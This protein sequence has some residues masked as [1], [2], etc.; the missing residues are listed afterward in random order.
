MGK[1]HRLLVGVDGS[2]ASFHA[3][4]ESCKLTG[5]WVTVVAVAPFYEGDLRS[6]WVSNPRALLTEAC[7]QALKEAQELADE[8][9]TVINTV[10]AVGAPHE[11]IVELAARGS[12]DLIVMG[13]KGQSLV[14]RALLGS[15]SRRVIGYSPVDVLVVPFKAQVGWSKILLATD[16]S[17]PSQKATARALELAQ[18]YG[19]ELTVLTVRESLGW[20][21]EEANLAAVARQDPLQDHVA[22][23]ALEAKSR[24]LSAKGLVL[25]GTPYN[26]ITELAAQEQIDLIVMGS[27]GHTGLKRLLMGNVTE[28]VIGHASCPVLVI[29]R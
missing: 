21:S 15:V 10:C 8:V 16:G 24:N 1:Y 4:R 11:Q 14:E 27:H 9:G 26:T 3:L 6:V 23:I 7:N 5:S 20:K 12:R 13:A 19:S 17:P 18:D 22:K 25:N 2:E 29:R 28:K